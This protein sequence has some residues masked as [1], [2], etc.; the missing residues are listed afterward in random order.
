MEKESMT[1]NKILLAVCAKAAIESHA[2]LRSLG[3]VANSR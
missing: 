2:V 3:V 1:K